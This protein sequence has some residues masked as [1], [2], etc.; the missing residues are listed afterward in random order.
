[1]ELCAQNTKF[2][3]NHW[4]RCGYVF[5]IFWHILRPLCCQW[6]AR[7]W[8]NFGVFCPQD[9]SYPHCC[10]WLFQRP[11]KGG[12]ESDP[13][14]WAKNTCVVTTSN[15]GAVPEN[16]P[17]SRWQWLLKWP[18]LTKK[19]R[20]GKWLELSGSILVVAR[21]FTE[22]L[23]PELYTKNLVYI[24]LSAHPIFHSFFVS[25]RPSWA[26]TIATWSVTPFLSTPLGP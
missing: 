13:G 25:Y 26:H 12:E 21:W 8:A 18:F 5:G 23:V 7:V 20:W 16:T 4:Q 19:R 1:M 11:K 22:L 6:L 3:T 14:F 9:F 10:W 17:F 24:S 2:Y 15:N